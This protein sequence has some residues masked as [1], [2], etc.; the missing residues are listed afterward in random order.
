MQPAGSLTPPGLVRDDPRWTRPLPWTRL[1][2]HD[3]GPRGFLAFLVLATVNVL[4]PLWIL[5][6]AAKGLDRPRSPWP[7][8]SRRPCRF[9]SC[10]PWSFFSQR[11]GGVWPQPRDLL[12]EWERPPA[13]RSWCFWFPRSGCC[14]RRRWRKLVLLAVATGLAAGVTAAGWLWIDSRSMPAIEHYEWANGF[15]VLIPGAYLV[16]IVLGWS[17]RC[18]GSTGFYD[19]RERRSPATKDERHGRRAVRGL[20]PGLVFRRMLQRS[21]LSIRR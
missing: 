11:N 9:R 14:W 15:L 21:G 10:T 12:L 4:L 2:V 19:D 18:G 1:I 7:C 16:G 13:F 3:I 8:R 17:K 20:P 6:L 5:G